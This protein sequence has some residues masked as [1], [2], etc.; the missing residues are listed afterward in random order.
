MSKRVFIQATTVGRDITALDIYH[1]SITASNLLESNVAKDDLISGNYYIVDDNTTEFIAVCNDAGE[2]QDQTGSLSI[3]TFS[4]S[5]RFFDVYSTDPTATV[6]IT[7]PIAD[8]PIPSTSG[9]LSQTVDFRT[10]PSFI[11]QADASPAY[12]DLTGFAGW[13]DAPS[14]GN[15]LS[16]NNPLTISQNSFTGSR[17]DNFYAVFS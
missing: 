4:P 11:I 1:T 15:L 13:Y 6:E 9:S 2:C 10:Y 8:G 16:T 3:S 7:Y 5:I 14:S 12:P 17:G